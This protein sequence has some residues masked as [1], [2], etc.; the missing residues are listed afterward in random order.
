VACGGGF[1][2]DFADANIP[3]SLRVVCQRR[4]LGDDRLRFWGLAFGSI[5]GILDDNGFV[6]D[7]C[8]TVFEGK[9]VERS[10]TFRQSSTNRNITRQ[11]NKGDFMMGQSQATAYYT[12]TDENDNRSPVAI[13]SQ[14]L[15]VWGEKKPVEKDG[16]ETDASRVVLI[17][18][19]SRVV[20]IGEISLSLAMTP[21][22]VHRV[23]GRPEAALDKYGSH[24]HIAERYFDRA[25]TLQYSDMEAADQEVSKME[26]YEIVVQ[27]R[28]GWQ[29]E[30]DGTS[31]FGDETLGRL[32]MKYR[33]VESKKRRAVAFPT[34]G[35]LLT[36]C[37]PKANTPPKGKSV[38]F[39]TRETMRSY[40]C[41]INVWD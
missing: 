34:L 40:V 3:T 5:L 24:N 15:T 29:V 1:G 2:F 35:I 27:D 17:T 31:L 4:R 14:R 8:R 20:Q 33:H 11:F 36:G 26:L 23:L 28:N 38:F 25:L 41:G 39:C 10:R 37:N 12:Y 18:P 21:E 6:V 7:D 13:P 22:A 30:V 32:K 19:Q 16:L 9:R